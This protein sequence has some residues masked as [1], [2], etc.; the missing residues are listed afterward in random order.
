MPDYIKSLFR[1]ADIGQ[2]R[3]AITNPLQWA[4]VILL[5]GMAMLWG[6]HAPEWLLVMLAVFLALFMVL[7]IGAYIYFGIKNPDFLRSEQYSLSKMAIER[8]M[9]GTT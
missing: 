8:G 4:I 1:R 2:S 7:F 9:L 6:V 3:S 5:S